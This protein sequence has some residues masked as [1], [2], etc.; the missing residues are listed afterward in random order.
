MPD[1]PLTTIVSPRTADH[2]MTTALWWFAIL[3][4]GCLGGCVGSFFNVVWD[5][6]GTGTGIVFPR[7]RCPQCGHAIRWYHNLPVL[8][9]LMLRGRCYDCGGPIP[10]KHPLV[11]GFFA[12]L[13][14]LAGLLSPWL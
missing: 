1:W 6:L 9:W 8:G 4:L 5:R 11:E 13:F 7:S 3:W 10:I 14:I 12:T 2:L